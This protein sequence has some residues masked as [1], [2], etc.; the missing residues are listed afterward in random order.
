MSSYEYSDAWLLIFFIETGSAL[1]FFCS[2]GFYAKERCF[3]VI[4]ELRWSSYLKL[5]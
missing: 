1:Q 2:W 5:H 3:L 4:R